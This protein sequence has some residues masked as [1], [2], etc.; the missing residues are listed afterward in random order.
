MF[1]DIA[2]YT[3]LM[4]EDEQKAFELL[5]KNRLV[6]KPI[7]EKYNGKWLKEMGDGVLASFTTVIDAVYCAA[8]IQKTCKD[9]PDLNLRI[10]IHQGEVVFEDN[11][12]FGSGV[13]IASRLE[14]LAPVGG[15]LVSEAVHNN[16]L[17]KRDI[18]STYIGEE[19]LKNVKKPV[20]TY[21]VQVKGVEPL[22]L[23][24]DQKAAPEFARLG[25]TITRKAVFTAAA[26]MVLMVLSYFLYTNQDKESIEATDKSIAV[27]PFVNMSNDPDQEYFSDGMAEE[28]INA[29][30]QIPNLKVASRTSAFQYRGEE[31]DIKSIGEDLGVATILEGS[32]RKSNNKVRVTAQLINVSDGFHLWS[33]T[34][35]RELDDVFS[36]QSDM[37]KQIASV[38]QVTLGMDTRKRIEQRPTTDLEAYQL[39]LQGQYY[40]NKDS[41]V[42]LDT[43]ISL[44]NR[45]IDRDPD[46]ALAHAVLARTYI[47]SNVDWKPKPDWNEKAFVSFQQALH[48]D[49]NL[50]DAYVARGLWF[51]TPGNDFKHENAIRDFQKAIELKPGLNISYEL[52]SLVQYHVGLM[53]QSMANAKKGLE[54]EPT[55]VRA[56]HYI[57]VVSL[58]QGKYVEALKMFE[59]VSE[60]YVPFFRIALMAQTLYYLGRL[61]EAAEMIEQGLLEYPVEPQLNSSYAIILAKMGRTDEARR[62]MNLAIEN[63]S[64]LRHVHHLYHNLAGASALMGDKKEAVQWLTRASEE[65][66]PNYPSFNNDPNLA[67]LR[68]DPDFKA[69][70]LKLKTQW[71]YYKSL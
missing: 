46:F 42:A 6:Q 71:E 44:L 24:D 67:S 55:S 28:I 25:P 21:Q 22:R 17:N 30:V 23:V 56:R 14:S 57:A 60:Q 69:L 15:I 59:T 10:G 65:G 47:L 50:A 29:L 27:L 63:K 68:G 66:L 18:E 36:I 45:A 39:Y 48:L 3:A 49:P 26:I 33:Q 1:T 12:V 4:D 16:I 9:D 31:K 5:K 70:M 53:D 52:L 34:Y 7:I 40:I 11:D 61:D 43:A 13:N 58:L 38:L 8:C 20:R 2:G 35:E 54:L 41:F 19:Q 62:R 51:W 32:V 37:A 64:E